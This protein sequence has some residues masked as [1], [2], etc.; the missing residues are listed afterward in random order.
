MRYTSFI[1]LLYFWIVANSLIFADKIVSDFKMTYNYAE[2]FKKRP[3]L[4][5]WCFQP[6][7]RDILN[8]TAKLSCMDTNLVVDIIN[9]SLSIS[10]NYSDWCNHGLV[11]TWKNKCGK[12]PVPSDCN[13]QVDYKVCR[14]E[15]EKPENLCEYIMDS[16]DKYREG[17]KGMKECII[18]IQPVNLI[19]NCRDIV[20]GYTNPNNTAYFWSKWVTVHYRCVISTGMVFLSHF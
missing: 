15:C 8:V 3:D 14:T 7:E 18:T 16:D 20:Q 9:I 17:C 2:Y 4:H 12:Y 5:Q 13:L 1:L 6:N 19:E 10:L 11:K